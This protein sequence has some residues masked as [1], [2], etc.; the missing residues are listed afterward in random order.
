MRIVS[1]KTSA[2]TKVRNFIALYRLLTLTNYLRYCNIS[3]EI[4]LRAWLYFPAGLGFT[5]PPYLCKKYSPYNDEDHCSKCE[6][7]PEGSWDCESYNC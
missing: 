2:E 3:P 1:P 5:S 7:P 4:A 6:D